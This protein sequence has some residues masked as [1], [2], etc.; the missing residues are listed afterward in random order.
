M[1]WK[2]EKVK[3]KKAEKKDKEKS[4]SLKKSHF[5]RYKMRVTRE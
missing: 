5:C 4:L 1:N 3:E 2:N